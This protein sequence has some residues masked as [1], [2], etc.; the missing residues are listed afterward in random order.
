[1]SSSNSTHVVSRTLKGS[2]DTSNPYAMTEKRRNEIQDTA[3]R[4]GFTVEHYTKHIATIEK[5]QDRKWEKHLSLTRKRP[6]TEDSEVS[7][8]TRLD[9]VYRREKRIKQQQPFAEQ[10]RNQQASSSRG[11]ESSGLV[12]D[13]Q[14]TTLDAQQPEA[15][16]TE[17]VTA[18]SWYRNL[19][20][21]TSQAFKAWEKSKS[22]KPAQLIKPLEVMKDRIARSQTETNPA[23]LET[24]FEQL[25]DDVHKAEFAAVNKFVLR[26]CHMMNNGLD[27]IVNSKNNVN[28]PWDL[29]ADAFQLYT[30][31]SAEIFEVKLLRGLEF[32]KGEK[33]KKRNTDRIDPT[34]RREHGKFA[35]FYGH[36]ELVQGQWWPTQLTTV[37]DGAHGSPQAGIFGEKGKG[38]YSIIIS[39]G[40]GYGDVDNG[41]EVLYSGTTSD[42]ETP[43]DCTQR[44]IES[45]DE[46]KEP[47]RVIRSWNMSMKHPYRPLRGFRYDGLYDVVSYNVVDPALA[48]YRFRLVRCAGQPP[49]RN[50]DNA[51]RRPT[52]YEIEEYD[53][54]VSAKGYS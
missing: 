31:W 14:I 25:R 48:K 37:R 9:A 51:A 13:N 44:L 35:N 50:E 26:R 46:V 11:A 17:Q 49:I 52:R 36:G 42:T 33:G 41:D 43:T 29:K 30:R 22:K 8:Q 18:P 6:S 38:A 4:A 47:V 40:T 16:V 53:K 39:A 20:P 3:R 34:W 28:Y 12:T 19:N 32:Q 10:D 21:K 2:N 54:Q 1:M 45:C 5:E 15:Q 24:L 7:P 27:C 23:E